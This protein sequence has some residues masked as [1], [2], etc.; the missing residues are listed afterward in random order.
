MV[1]KGNARPQPETRQICRL[2]RRLH[3]KTGYSLKGGPNKLLDLLR[4]A[5]TLTVPSFLLGSLLRSLEEGGRTIP[6]ATTM[7]RNEFCVDMALII[8]RHLTYKPQV[9]RFLMV[10]ASPV[11]D[12]DWLW[13]IMYEILRT[14][15]VQTARAC[16][17]LA[18]HIDVFMTG[19]E[20]KKINFDWKIHVRNVPDSWRLL[21]T[22]IAA[23]REYVFPPATVTSGHRSEV[24][25]ASTLAHMFHL[26]CPR[27]EDLSTY[28]DSIQTNTTDMGVELATGDVELEQV[29]KAIMEGRRTIIYFCA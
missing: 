23:L 21:C 9:R 2:A 11:A 8:W 19:L 27:G 1:C 4:N 17:E 5:M 16:L 6:S 26:D 13:A 18:G 15:L 20:R 12:Y 24:H 29:C 7:R 14:D 28:M 22:S 25:K 10:D 3:S